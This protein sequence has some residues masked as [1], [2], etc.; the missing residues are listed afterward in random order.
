MTRRVRRPSASGARRKRRGD[1]REAPRARWWAAAGRPRGSATRAARPRASS[2]WPDHVRHRRPRFVELLEWP[3]A[4]L[5][6][7]P[8]SPR[9]VASSVSSGVQQRRRRREP[10][11]LNSGRTTVALLA[12]DQSSHAA[13]V[14]VMRG[15]GRGGTCA[16]GAHTDVEWRVQ[17]RPRNRRGATAVRGRV[18][19]VPWGVSACDRPSGRGRKGQRWSGEAAAL[20]HVLPSL[21]SLWVVGC[22]ERRVRS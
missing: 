18:C 13:A 19:R 5:E 16:C 6:R 21:F 12:W 3:A 4:A 1:G 2:T 15:E 17:A 14:P 9:A 7:R 11:R 20:F 22:G 10:P 8:P